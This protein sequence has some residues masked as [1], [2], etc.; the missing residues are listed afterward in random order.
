MQYAEEAFDQGQRV[1]LIH[2]LRDKRGGTKQ[3]ELMTHDGR[4]IQRTI[5]ELYCQCLG[6]LFG[7]TQCFGFVCID[8]GQ[9][10]RDIMWTPEY[11][12]QERCTVI[13]TRIM[14][15]HVRVP[16][17]PMVYLM[18]QADTIEVL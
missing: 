7:V 1:V 5:Q 12:A 13:V 18:V 6:D 17:P 3:N 14:M 9:F 11:C 10:F 4:H 16:M 8:E 2:N 15:D